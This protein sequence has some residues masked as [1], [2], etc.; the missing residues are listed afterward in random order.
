MS[1]N[2][3]GHEGLQLSDK[4]L[5]LMLRRTSAYGGVGYSYW[6]WRMSRCSDPPDAGERG[7]S[8]APNHRR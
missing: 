2:P 4:F 7:T 6:Q 8:N 1:C 5:T 3:Y